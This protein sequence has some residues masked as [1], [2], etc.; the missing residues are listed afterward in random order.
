M[1]VTAAVSLENED[2]HRARKIRGLGI[3]AKL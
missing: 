1:V 3:H 2:L